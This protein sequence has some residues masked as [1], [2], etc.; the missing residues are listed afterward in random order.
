[1][2]KE[3]SHCLNLRRLRTDGLSSSILI[4]KGIDL[5]AVQIAAIS[6]RPL[7][8]FWKGTQ[9]AP[10]GW[11]VVDELRP[12]IHTDKKGNIKS[13]GSKKGA[14]LR[15]LE[16][17]DKIFPSHDAYF[18]EMNSQL[19][20][21]GS[22]VDQNGSLHIDNSGLSKEDMLDVMTAKLGSQPTER[23]SLR[24]NTR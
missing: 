8:A 7:P 10:E 24:S 12:E 13:T 2:K 22:F 14:N 20:M 18:R 1:M 15:Y 3:I 19:N 16:K 17:E 4:I 6:S 5:G 23:R 9:N 21:S 11:A